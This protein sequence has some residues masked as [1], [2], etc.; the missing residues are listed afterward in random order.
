VQP[1]GRIVVAGTAN[2][3]SNFQF[4]V[5]RYNPSGNLDP[6]FGGDGR[7]ITDLGYADSAFAVAIQPDGKIVV[8]GGS[9]TQSPQ[10]ARIGLVRYLTN[11]ALDTSFGSGG[12]VVT[13]VDTFDYAF[14]L[15][16]QADG[17]IVVAGQSHSM[18]A[19]FDS[20]VVVVR[21]QTN[22]ALDGSFGTGG[23]VRTDFANRW[24][25]ARD[26]DVLSDGRIVVGGSS[27][28]DGFTS[29]YG[30]L[31]R[32]TSTGSLDSSLNGGFVCGQSCGKIGTNLGG[33]YYD[34][35]SEI[36][37]RRPDGTEDGRIIASG[38]FGVARYNQ[39]GTLDLSFSGDGINESGMNDGE[40]VALRNDGRIVRV[41]ANGGNFGIELY[42]AMGQLETTCSL[43]SSA[44]LDFNGGE[45]SAY[46]VAIQQDGKILLAG[47]G[48]VFDANDVELARFMGGCNRRYMFTKYVV[49]Y[50]KFVH[51]QDKVGPSWPGAVPDGLIRSTQVV[52][53]ATEPAAGAKFA[54]KSYQFGDLE[55][56]AK[57]L[58][59]AAAA[60]ATTLLERSN[61]VL[62][63]AIGEFAL[64]I[65]RE[66]YVM[67]PATV[68]APDVRLDF[69]RSNQ[70]GG[71]T[72][73][74]A[75]SASTGRFTLGDPLNPGRRIS[76][77]QVTHLCSAW[78][79]TERTAP[80]AAL[81]LCFAP[82]PDKETRNRVF[83][84]DILGSQLADVGAPVG[85]CMEAIE[86]ETAKQRQ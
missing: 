71:Y 41:G 46:A 26:V 30:I 28:Q 61:Q 33:G 44:T 20:D 42:N 76:I 57:S 38:A 36:A 64:K 45:D 72:C 34:W 86:S 75:E 13:D 56:R 35:I 66:D 11:G 25:I 79:A 53:P 29:V 60:A 65:G 9:D 48:E 85:V 70:T 54:Y 39:N 15:A 18:T 23:I 22:G 78:D 62:S 31:A 52:V 40:G 1:D 47:G 84:R 5:A 43:L 83:V 73:N 3:K 67:L 69:P 37:V 4:L 32:Y 82:Q 81:L 58:A 24:D 74:V 19:A 17:R 55:T 51:P 7:V 6:T 14:G 10:G 77:G 49:A 16:L 68:R 27:W 80:E 8:A 2:I 50:H 59:L 21:Y 63:T 12:I